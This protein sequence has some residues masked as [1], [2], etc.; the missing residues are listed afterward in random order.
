EEDPLA[1]VPGPFVEIRGEYDLA[2]V[3]EAAGL[4]IEGELAPFRT[5]RGLADGGHGCETVTATRR[6]RAR[7]RDDETADDPEPHHETAPTAPDTEPHDVP[8]VPSEWGHDDRGRYRRG[9]SSRSPASLGALM[10]RGPPATP[11]V[12]LGRTA[13]ATV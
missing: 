9:A 1:F 6:E 11:T 4:E 3:V 7:R 5:R 2:S 12:A 10:A 13:A 8:P